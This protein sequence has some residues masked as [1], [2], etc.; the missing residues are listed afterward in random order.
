MD[1]NHRGQCGGG[2]GYLMESAGGGGP[3]GFYIDRR[4]FNQE[5]RIYQGVRSGQ[6]SPGEFR[7]LENQQQRIRLVEDRMRADGRLDPGEKTRLNQM[8]N[9]SERAICRGTH[10]NWRPGFYRAN[11]RPGCRPIHWRLGWR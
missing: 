4:E 6:L 3:Y 11:W 1:R 7:R 8:L 10:N 5:R 2:R 9:H